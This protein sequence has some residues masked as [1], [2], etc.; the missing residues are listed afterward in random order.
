MYG[1][2]ASV[3]H[4]AS[5]ATA[6]PVARDAKDADARQFDM[7][8]NLMGFTFFKQMFWDLQSLALIEIYF[9]VTGH[10]ILT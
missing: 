7:K 2:T 1:A 4:P 9:V 3:Q 10:S 5:P 6:G 8:T